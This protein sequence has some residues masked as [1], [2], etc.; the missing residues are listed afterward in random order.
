MENIL[1]PMMSL[2]DMLAIASFLLDFLELKPNNILQNNVILSVV[3][4]AIITGIF[5]H[6]GN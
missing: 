4:T 1:K 6:E 5:V 2:N 3:F